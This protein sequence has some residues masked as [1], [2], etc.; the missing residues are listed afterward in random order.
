MSISTSSVSS[1]NVSTSSPPL[2]SANSDDNTLEVGYGDTIDTIA[3]ST[4]IDRDALLA[5]NPDVVNPEVLYPGSKLK[6]PDDAPIQL[7]QANTGTTTDVSPTNTTST[8]PEKTVTQFVAGNN[9]AVAA[10]NAQLK[11]L[12]ALQ[13]KVDTEVKAGLTGPSAERAAKLTE[14]IK[15]ERAGITREL[16][17][18]T[19]AANAIANTTQPKGSIGKDP[20]V[21]NS[22]TT[23]SQHQKANGLTTKEVDAFNNTLGKLNRESKYDKPYFAQTSYGSG[24]AYRPRE[25]ADTKYNV[26][27]SPGWSDLV[28]SKQVTSS[29]QRVISRMA[30]NEGGRMD[31]LQAWDSEIVTL[32]AMQKTINAGGT[33][34]LPKQV[35]EF[36]QTNPDKYKTLFADKGWT[37]E[38]TGKGTGPGDYTMS[39]KDPTDPN[40]KPMTGATLR[41]YIH[42]NNPANWEK[43][44]TP[45]LE[46][47]R[48]VDFQKKQIIDFRDRLN[49]AVD[50]KPKGYDFK[51]SDYTTSEQGAALVLDQ[52][53]N[54]PAHV[55]GSF[56]KALN[57]FFAAN[58]NAPKDPTTWTAEQRAKYEPQ[59]IANY[60]AQRNATNMTDPQERANHI[61]NA[62]SGLSAAPGSFVRTP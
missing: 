30:D 20:A 1:N 32:G 62:N 34:E 19:D 16:A 3:E 15:A 28:S 21:A 37:V 39:F 41:N 45:L 26:A 57:T 11:Q 7:A 53:V 54:R 56:G 24:P 18:R 59:I 13:A 29:E 58:P 40:A 52:S 61:T 49:G 44:M 10:L 50:Q 43:T 12:D 6:L 33:G 38:H 55:S 48:D 60:V 36:S 42:A 22:L 2:A 31:A 9:K 5:A 46:A 23:L 47:G 25:A 27:T 51:I 4:G 35:Y 8:V 14:Q 17:L